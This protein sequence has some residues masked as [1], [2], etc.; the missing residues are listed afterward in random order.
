MLNELRRELGYG[1][2]IH[3][4]KNYI[5]R[6]NHDLL[7]LVK[8]ALVNIASITLSYQMH[9]LSDNERSALDEVTKMVAGYKDAIQFAIKAFDNG[10]T[11][12][13]VDQAVRVDDAPAL[14]AF[15]VLAREIAIEEQKN[16]DFVSHSFTLV[17]GVLRV[18]LALGVGLTIILILGM[19]WL[20]RSRIVQPV[21]TMTDVTNNL[22]SGNLDVQIPYEEQQNEIGKM[23]RALAVFRDAAIQQQQDR[24][25]LLIAKEE[26]DKANQMKSDFLSSMSHELRTPLNAILGFTQILNIDAKKSLTVDQKAC[27]DQ[28]MTGGQ[29]LLELINEILDLAKIESG[30][31]TLSIEDVCARTVLDECTSLINTMAEARGIELI[32]E[33]G[34]HSKKAIRA[35]YTRFKQSLLNLLSNAVKYN[36]ENGKITI[37]CRDTPGGMCRI[38]VSDTGEGIPEDMLNGIFEPFNRLG[39]ERTEIEGTGIGLSITR[40]LVEIMGGQ[41]GVSSEVGKG[42]TF[43]IELVQ[44]EGTYISEVVAEAGKADDNTILLAD[45]PY[46]NKI[47]Y[48]EDNPANL[49]LMELIIQNIEGISMISAHNAELGIELAKVEK[50]GLIILDINLPGMDGYQAL[51]QLQNLTGT[52]DIPVIALSANAMPRDVERGIEAGFEQYLTKPVKVE[53]VVNSIKT[54]LN[55]EVR[56]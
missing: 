7:P 46:S 47:L 2:M 21:A 19:V 56:Q 18:Q 4:F 22:A 48:V 13:S 20:I 24:A 35:D 12:R 53:E 42:S 34:C 45:V 50:P 27:T 16:A 40:Q 8:K 36:S 28:I 41:I 32:V 26:A 11:S 3:N 10:E 1:G 38:S 44:T 25:S 29:H 30:K 23:C 31:V 37:E 5:I 33:E 43:W 15:K 52:Q 17:R 54:I 51:T 39:A 9:I 14:D 6:N 55:I 49:K